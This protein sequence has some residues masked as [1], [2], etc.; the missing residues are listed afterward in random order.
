MASGIVGKRAHDARLA[1][2]MR[3]HGVGVVLTFDAAAFRGI[4]GITPVVPGSPLP[5]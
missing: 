5:V 2:L 4:G 3:V 1:A